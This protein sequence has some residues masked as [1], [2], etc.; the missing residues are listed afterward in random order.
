MVYLSGEIHRMV[1]SLKVKARNLYRKGKGKGR[2]R[3]LYN[4]MC[5]ICGDFKR[6]AYKKK[7]KVKEID[8]HVCLKIVICF[9]LT[10]AE[11]I[12]P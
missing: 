2:E 6:D 3:G 11:L 10:L 12:S 9:Q 7:R 5:L 1:C 8:L 4:L